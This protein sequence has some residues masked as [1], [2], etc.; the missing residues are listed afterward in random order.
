[1]E[2][3][4]VFID[5]ALALGVGLL[6]GLQRE[7]SGSAI[8]GIRTFAL[9]SMSG[10]VAASLP[11]PGGA[12]AVAA[13]LIAV[14]GLCWIGNWTRAPGDQSPGVTTEAAMILMF[15]VGA[16]VVWG[17]RSA[18]VAVGASMAVLLHAKPLLQQFTRRL[19]EGDLRAIMQFAAITLIILPVAPDEAY[20]PFGVLNP[21][22]IWLM[23]VLI[24]GISLAAYVAYRLL[25][26]RHG[27]IVAGVLGG[28][29]SST[30]TTVSFARRARQEPASAPVATLAILIAST[31]LCVRLLV[32]LWV[33]ARDQWITLA[34]PVAVLVVAGVLCVLLA[35]LRVRGDA[36]PMPLQE[37]PT[38]LKSALIFAGLF[39]LVLFASAAARKYFGDQGTY[40]VAFL[41][42]LTDMDAI[43]LSLGGQ[44]AGGSLDA[45]TGARA[46]I[47]AFIANTV[48]KTAM[49]GTLGGRALLVRVGPLMLAQ[50][51]IGVALLMWTPVLPLALWR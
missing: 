7:R 9:I 25:G 40:V 5:L 14:C 8:A 51:A 19:G 41:S 39:A 20:D 50:V 11:E 21:W 22:R 29:I 42:G 32:V 26:E 28:L 27:S 31:I 18:G 35:R 2:S 17:P 10:A 4:K 33:V 45:L 43:S 23:V 49:A 1:M 3:T 38:Q 34:V 30:A 13:G 6:V 37:N 47:V 12:W 48:F 36:A 24:V 15:L 16:L 44:V 46:I